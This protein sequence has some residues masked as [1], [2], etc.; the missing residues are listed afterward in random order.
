MDAKYH[1]STV[2]TYP[3]LLILVCMQNMFI[4]MYVCFMW[5]LLYL[6]FLQWM[7][8]P[9]SAVL[10]FAQIVLGQVSLI[11]LSSC[12]SETVFNVAACE[13]I[14]TKYGEPCTTICMFALSV[15]LKRC[16]A[17]TKQIFTD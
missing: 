17:F 3:C 15:N 13:E 1:Y 11:M 5:I 2:M 4:C 16:C 10:V 6:D 7:L 12:W 9:D 8:L 14:R